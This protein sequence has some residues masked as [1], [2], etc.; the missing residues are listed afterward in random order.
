MKNRRG[1]TLIELLVVIAI[2]AVL[3]GILMP[4]LQRVKE[5]AQSTQCQA[6]LR[7]YGFALRMYLDENNFM[8]PYSFNWLYADGSG[9]DR[10]HDLSK[11]L[12]LNPKLG[13]SLWPYLAKKDIHVC[14]TFKKI[15]K[16]VGCGRCNGT[17]I[18]IDPQY[19]YCM[20]S[21]LH[22][23]AWNSVPAKYKTRIRKTSSEH[24]VKNPAK[25]FA[26]S[27]ENTWSIPGL[28]GA[29]INDNNLRSTPSLTTDCF[30]TF[31]KTI[32]G[33]LDSGMANAVF[34]DGHTQRVSANPPGN[35]YILSWPSGG[36]APMDW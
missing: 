27:E 28:S 24:N 31:H 3:M 25:V 4:A 12:D 32:G 26:F 1:F 34:V 6:N 36:T 20:N 18:P 29:G 8:F 11:N 14:P 21:Y 2:I 10:W 33:D 17:T 9:G 23:D 5:Q 16:S 13:G 19:G 15:A 30:A 22:G 7:N 35:T